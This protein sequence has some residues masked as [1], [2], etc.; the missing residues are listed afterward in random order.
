MATIAVGAGCRQVGG[1]QGQRVGGVH[2]E[3]V[4][5][6][7]GP[8]GHRV[9]QVPGQHRVDLDGVHGGH[10]G[11]QRQ[12]ERAQPGSDLEHDVVDVSSA[13]RTMRRTVFASCTKFWP[14]RLVGRSPALG[15]GPHLGRA[16]QPRVAHPVSVHPGFPTLIG[17][18]AAAAPL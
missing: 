10:R 18:G 4:G 16:E 13:A 9:R 5:E 2:G 8:F 3:P 6:R 14:S 1:A 7:R 17:G 11:Q 15:Q 12:R